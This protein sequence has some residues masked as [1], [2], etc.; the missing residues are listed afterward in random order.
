M[1]LFYYYFCGMNKSTI[2]FEQIAIAFGTENR[3]NHLIIVETLNDEPINTYIVCL[4]NFLFWDE[5][6]KYYVVNPN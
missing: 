3:T 5:K 2:K 4:N 1:C 6:M